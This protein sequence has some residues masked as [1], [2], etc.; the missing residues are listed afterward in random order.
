MLLFHAELDQ[1]SVVTDE[2]GRTNNTLYSTF[3][4]SRPQK[5]ETDAIALITALQSSF[6]ALRCHIVHLSASSAIPL[7]RAAKSSGLNLTVET[8]FHYLCLSSE[9]IPNGRPEFK[10]CPPVRGHANREQLWDALREGLIDCV[11]SDHSPCV[12]EL[13]RLDQGDIMGAWGGISTLGLG[14]SL[15]WTEG[16][17]RGFT[18]NQIVD[19]TSTQSAKHSGLAGIK[20]KLDAGHDAD[21]IVWDPDARWTVR[22]AWQDAIMFQVLT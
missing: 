17:Q 6:S 14:L 10:C 1:S 11:V 13:K 4:E 18:L 22:V 20:G 15:L 2:S 19:W 3:L 12:A 5:L 9:D 21:L 7:I 16:R 8:C